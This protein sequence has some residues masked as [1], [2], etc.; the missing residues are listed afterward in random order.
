M[1]NK[2]QICRNDIKTACN[3]R[4]AIALLVVLFIIMA[5]TIL[6]VGYLTRSD[7]ELSAGENVD[8]KADL[9]YL[10]ES[11][12][13]H[14]KGLLL[15]PT[16]VVTPP[17]Y[18]TGKAGQQLSSGNDYYDVNVVY[19]DTGDANSYYLVTSTAYRKS[20]STR[21]AQS[22]LTTTIPL[23]LPVP[24]KYWKL[25]D[26]EGTT[27][28]D[29]SANNIPGAQYGI[30]S[31]ADDGAVNFGPANVTLYG[32]SNY[33]GWSASFNGFGYIDTSDIE[34]AGGAND[35]ASSIKIPTGYKV[36]LYQHGLFDG[37]HH[38]YDGD[39]A[40]RYHNENNFSGDTF[41]GGVSLDSA[42]SSLD[43]GPVTPAT[44]MVVLYEN[45]NYG[46][47]AACFPGVGIYRLADILLS[48]NAK[49]DEASSIKV[50]SGYRVTLYE[51][52]PPGGNTAVFTADDSSFSSSQL[53]DQVSSLKVEYIGTNTGYIK[54]N[55]AT[56]SLTVGNATVSFG[57]CMPAT[58]NS[59]APL[60]VICTTNYDYQV[61]VN[62]SA[63]LVVS[64]VS[65]SAVTALTGAS[66]MAVNDAAWHHVVFTLDS[67]NSKVKL[68]IDGSLQASNSS[69]YS[70]SYAETYFYLGYRAKYTSA[71]SYYLGK[72]DEV[73][74][75]ATALNQL[76]IEYL[77][78]NELL[79]SAVV[80]TVQAEDYSS[81]SGVVKQKCPED[82]GQ[83]V[84]G[85]QTGDWMIYS[86]NV[87]TAKSYL[88]KFRVSSIYAGRILQVDY[89]GGA[90][91][92][93]QVTVPFTSAWTNYTTCTMTGNLP[94]GNI[95]L[96]IYA[97]NGGGGYCYS[98]NWFSFQ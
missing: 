26:G 82:S 3:A 45:T 48:F 24:A 90:N 40:T 69:A 33:G 43:I 59:N 34:D 84:G 39:K 93:G 7:V 9:D 88:F 52:D 47:W 2:K 21:I 80:T 32:N 37:V 50:P 71:A 8:M 18:W 58:Y 6:T 70:D 57:M 64:K 79:P 31:W 55:A 66:T 78:S 11:G 62:S 29:Y 10:A 44:A 92:V 15:T 83:E 41:F 60:A 74:V 30:L 85:I 77:A 67:T 81:M 28:A 20:G 1:E 53:N 96:R 54:D 91:V 87:P 23:N 68:Y 97:A 49:N 4:P 94:A 12:L 72:I 98:F 35:A 56:P 63:K 22:K 13:E 14:A 89:N 27:I 42:V 25:D 65:T 5:I 86:V 46:G 95:N 19:T 17:S 61:G 51:N 75:Y 38:Y 76:Q 16:G 36:V 73:V